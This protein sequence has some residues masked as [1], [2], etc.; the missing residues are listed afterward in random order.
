VAYI[1]EKNYF[2][3]QG[4]HYGYGTVVKLKPAIYRGISKIE[5]CD[6]VMEFYEGLTSGVIRFCAIT[7][8]IRKK[9]ARDV[10]IS[11]EDAIEYIITPVYV[12]LQPV[13]KKALVNY[14]Q[15]DKDHRPDTFLG[16]L[17]YIIIMIGGALFYDRVLIW[18]IA[19]IIYIRYLV[20]R[21][22]D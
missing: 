20:N 3:Y 11:P 16:T 8:D 12:E 10:I 9:A 7:N 22:R 13:W 5:N 4:K 1:Y 17:W 2:T 21:Y 18:I 19:T 15:T 6:G 14:Y